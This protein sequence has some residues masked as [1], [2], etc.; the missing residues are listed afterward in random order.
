VDP[1]RDTPAA[2]K[3]YV[4]A[5]HPRLIGLTGSPEQIAAVAKDHGVYFS[6]QGEKGA[7]DY[8][9]DHSRVATLFGPKGEPLAIIPHD[10]GA[11]AVAAE[12]K[13]WVG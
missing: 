2:L 4:A 6:K 10:Q 9:V 11:E 12:L 3:E 1:E 5:F 7:K 8:L 13:R